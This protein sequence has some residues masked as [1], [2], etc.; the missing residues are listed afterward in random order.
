MSI[1]QHLNT[2]FDAA[3]A[4][5]RRS[6]VWAIAVCVLIAG[7]T[8][9]IITH[10]PWADEW[11]AALIALEAPDWATMLAWLRYEGHPWLWY[12]LLRIL[13]YLF[14]PENV[15]WIAALLC[16]AI[17]QVSILFFSPFARIERLMLAS[18]Q[19]VLFEFL[20]VSRGTSL[21]VALLTAAMLL[22]RR[23]AFWLILALLP[24]VDFLFGVISGALL[25]FQWN[26]RRLW[27][28]GVGLW[29]AGSAFAAWSV[30][31]ATDMVSAFD[32]M[33]PIMGEPNL[34]Q[35]LMTWLFKIGS[36]P[37]PFQGGIAPQWN[38]PVHPI[39]GFAWVIMGL[40]CWVLT[41]D[42]PLQRLL[43]A[44]FFALTLL[45]SA[46]L[47][48]LGLRHLMLG[49]FLLILCVWRQ[50]AEKERP[51]DLPRVTFRFWLFLLAI[52]GISSATLS[53]THGFDSA[54]LTVR[55]ME[56]LGGSEKHWV[57][58]P[59]WRSAALAGRSDISFIR[60]DEMCTFRFARWDY[61]Y[62]PMRSNE[63]L[64]RWASATRKKLGQFYLVSDIKLSGFPEA[65]FTPIS[66]IPKGYSGIDYYIYSVGEGEPAR[67][68]SLEPCAASK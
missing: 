67:R 24:M 66:Q 45:M 8:Y 5:F 25:V 11:Q 13:G 55:E 26:D 47:Y 4:E 10:Q 7:Q 49:A 62:A 22:W 37:L 21:G 1:A 40:L 54:P 18:S 23:K 2:I 34:V 12:A 64:K 28:P 56:R 60:P 29:L 65:V 33:A 59:E 32:A 50:C 61:V 27:W 44:G 41:K 6:A 36:I 9:L 43:I 46:A 3:E 35:R 20:T 57:M 53:S 31:P 30:I 14:A 58:M 17:V 52:C 63:A 51:K 15:L 42:Q 38:S 68:H 39:H 19:Y 48:P 16:A